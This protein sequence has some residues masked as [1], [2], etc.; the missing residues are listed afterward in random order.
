V[1]ACPLVMNTWERN[2][3]VEVFCYV[4]PDEFTDY[5]SK[6]FDYEFTG[7]SRFEIPNFSFPEDFSIGLIVGSSGSGKTQI[8]TNY[9]DFKD[10]PLIWEPNKA[11]VSHFENPEQAVRKLMACGLSSLPSLCKPYHV[12]SNG[13]KFRAEMARKIKTGAIIDEFTSV[14][15]R[16]TAISLS[17]ALSKYIRK[18][19]LKNI[20]IASVHRDIIDWL[21]PDWIFDC[22]NMN[23]EEFSIE[24]KKKVAKI[25]I[26]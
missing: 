1:W 5:L 9:F 23:I 3:M 4:E 11:I 2:K 24:Y 19:G 20:V 26:F 12:L 13:E 7:K 22:D 14:V 17:I 15:N 10:E 8:L 21:E 18:N 25:E 6:C 16:E